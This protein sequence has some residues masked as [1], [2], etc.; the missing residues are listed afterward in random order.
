MPAQTK[1][2]IKID[3]AANPARRYIR[4]S[5][6]AALFLLLTLSPLLRGGTFFPEQLLPVLFFV[7][8]I[9]IIFLAEQRPYWKTMELQA[10]DIC[11][12]ALGLAYLLS[13]TNAVSLHSALLEI[14]K[15]F[16]GFMV[17][18][19]ARNLSQDGKSLK[20]LLAAVYLAAIVL[21]LVGWGAA[22][23]W[24]SFPGAYE[25]GHIRST[26]QYHNALA[27][28]LA[29][30]AL[31]GWALGIQEANPIRSIV[32]ICCNYFLLVILAG[33][34]SRGT[35]I[36]YPIAAAAFFLL[37]SAN[38]RGKAYSHLVLSLPLAWF[39]AAF[40]YSA[41][42]SNQPELSFIILLGGLGIVALAAWFYTSRLSSSLEKASTGARMV[43][44]LLAGLISL[45]LIMAGSL[46][47]SHQ[48]TG[49]AANTAP[50]NVADKFGRLS[51]GEHS[52][53][54][55]LTTY[56]DALKIIK[57]YPF[58]GAGGGSWRLLYHQYATK[59]YTCNE[60]HNFYLKTL[61]EAGIP[62]LM[63]LLAMCFAFLGLI[64]KIWREAAG[65]DRSLLAAAAIIVMLTGLHS[66]F[67]FD[68]SIPAVAFMFFAIIGGLQGH[69]LGWRSGAK[70]VNNKTVKN[71]GA[72]RNGPV[73]RIILSASDWYLPPG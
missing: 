37:I 23:G 42:H 46:Y 29:S 71:G 54:E 68:L 50:Q 40:V 15:I 5:Y 56:K 28:Y 6:L 72:D 1:N 10:L 31:I 16:A 32:S 44:A 48:V 20:R 33:T 13:L 55:R 53:Q 11:F 60:M 39:T 3:P 65:E 19:I 17:Y 21:A 58:T 67:D 70:S 4:C 35:V 8:L 18:W 51:V 63:A 52:V 36:L 43:C 64:Y 57:D 12:L 30:A 49:S 62:G 41:L 34:M 7:G 22:M 24:V 61:L 38:D 69:V 27:I 26:L 73:F 45:L 47:M 59:F 14:M 2:L 9:F 25:D 66:A